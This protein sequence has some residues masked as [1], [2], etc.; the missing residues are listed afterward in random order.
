[1]KVSSGIRQAAGARRRALGKSL[2]PPG[3]DYRLAR[4]ALLRDFRAGLRSRIDLCDAH[5]ELVRAARH[6]G[7]PLNSPCPVCDSEDLRAVYYTYEGRNTRKGRARRPEDVRA[8]R[9]KATEIDCYV[10]EVC[11]DCS[12]NHLIRQFAAGRREAV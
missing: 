1:M 7:E 5:P 4:L 9:G 10:I 6:I 8:L 2:P 11:A 3:V 12:W